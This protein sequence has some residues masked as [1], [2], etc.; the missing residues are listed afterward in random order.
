MQSILI[1]FGLLLTYVSADPSTWEKSSGTADTTSVRARVV[2]DGVEQTNGTLAAFGPDGLINA[3][4]VSNDLYSEFAVDYETTGEPAGNYFMIQ[5]SGNQGESHTLHFSPDGVTDITLTPDY[6]YIETDFN[7]YEFTGSMPVATTTQAPGGTPDGTPCEHGYDC[8]KDGQVC[9][10]AE[11]GFNLNICFG[12]SCTDDTDCPTDFCCLDLGIGQ[13]SQCVNNDVLN[14]VA[15][16]TGTTHTCP[17]GSGS[18]ATQAPT[19]PATL[20]D[21]STWSYDGTGSF[22]NAA[23]NVVVEVGGVTKT[24]GKVAVA[25]ANGDIRGVGEYSLI[26]PPSNYGFPV[27]IYQ[28]TVDAEG[29]YTVHYS[30]DNS[31]AMQLSPGYTWSDTTT[32]TT[33][34][35]ARTETV[36]LV[37]GWNWI[38]VSVESTQ[39]FNDIFSD[40]FQANDE[41]KCSGGSALYYDNYGWFSQAIDIDSFASATMCK[42]YVQ[43]ATSASITGNPTTSKTYNL[44]QG[45]NWLGIPTFTQAKLKNW[46]SDAGFQASDEFKLQSGSALYYDNYGWFSQAL[47][48]DADQDLIVKANEGAKLYK[49]TAGSYTYTV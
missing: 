20:A 48:K 49:Q 29:P 42:I 28:P 32:T 21:P 13:G 12:S 27:T 34:T 23:L 17:T 40:G 6:T 41:I 30:E 14:V 36:Q 38:S 45:W 18:I 15:S 5:I 35:G 22:N 16:M 1:S 10:H 26:S 37:Q 25:N 44:V 31:N 39:S 7:F 24:S 9:G 19:G 11:S 47:S 43:T 8:T 2:I 33:F 46:I 4:A 3:V